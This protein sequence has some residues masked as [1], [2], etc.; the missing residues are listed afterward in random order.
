MFK[1][2]SLEE[3]KKR[4]QRSNAIINNRIHWFS[5]QF[6]TYFSYCFL[7]LGFS[8]D[9]VTVIFFLTGLTGAL[10]SLT[11]G[12]KGS[13]I[14]YLCWRLHIIIDMSDGDVARFNQSFSHRGKYWDSM[15][16]TILNP[17]YSLLIPLGFYFKTNDNGFLFLAI[18]LMFSQSILLA[19]KYNIASEPIATESISS[20]T[21]STKLR[22]RFTFFVLEAIG[23]E[24]FILISLSLNLLVLPAMGYK[25]VFG[26][27]VILNM[28]VAGIKFYQYSYYGKIYSR[29]R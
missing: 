5:S 13:I 10:F 24:G 23:M 8:A 20:R 29:S 17:M 2:I 3:V 6:S 18:G 7:R 21:S 19:T 11:G 15:V 28:L 14:T 27:Y 4:T 12:L 9:K 22:R 25:V 16:H 1:K 26:T